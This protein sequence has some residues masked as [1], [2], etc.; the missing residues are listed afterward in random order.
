ME[1]PHAFR[2]D[3]QLF[4]G[5]SL[6]LTAFIVPWGACFHVQHV[7]DPLLRGASRVLWPRF[8][9]NG[10]TL[11]AGSLMHHQKPEGER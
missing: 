4:L 2:L 8:W 1:W 10:L 3:Y 11:V 7:G 5:R 9:K 6:S